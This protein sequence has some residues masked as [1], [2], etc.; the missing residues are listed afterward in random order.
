MRKKSRVI[1]KTKIDGI[2]E[3]VTEVVTCKTERTWEWINK[4]EGRY[5]FVTFDEEGELIG[6]GGFPLEWIGP[7]MD[8]NLY[9]GTE[10]Q[11][12]V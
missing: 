10:K 12:R 6:G 2:L 7:S 1:R 3:I 8:E 9:Q 11:E 4:D 5:D